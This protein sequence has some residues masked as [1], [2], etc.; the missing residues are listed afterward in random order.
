MKPRQLLLV[1][2]SA[3]ALA[4]CSAREDSNMTQQMTDMTQ[5]INYIQVNEASLQED[6]EADIKDNPELTTLTNGKARVQQN[7]KKR[8]EA[9]AS[10]KED[11]NK[12]RESTEQKKT[13]DSTFRSTSRDT[14]QTIE[15]YLNDYDQLLQQEANYYA[16]IASDEAKTADFEDQLADLDQKHQQVQEQLQNIEGKLTNLNNA[17]EKEEGKDA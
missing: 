6:F 7:L 9:L 3:L 13:D 12:L 17:I 16:L 15:G 14:L 11:L 2:I 8:Q 4:A 10:A 1:G 5:Q